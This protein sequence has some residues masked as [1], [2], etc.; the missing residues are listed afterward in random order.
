MLSIDPFV[1]EKGRDIVGL[2]LNP[3]DQAVVL[4]VEEKTQIQLLDRT[5]LL[6]PMGL[7]YIKGVTHDSIRHGTTTLFAAL[8]VATGS[9]IA[10]RKSRNRHQEVL[11]FPRRIDTEVPSE[12]DVRLIVDNDCTHKHIKVRSWPA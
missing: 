5:L 1:V 12:L 2:Y 6:L 10:E 11:N 3:P 8:D 9:V 7:G 4:C